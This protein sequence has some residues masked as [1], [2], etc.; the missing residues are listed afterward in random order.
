[1]QGYDALRQSAAWLD[2][3]GRGVIT[4]TG[5][6]RV[7]LL[8]AITTNHIEQLKAGE[9]C[10]A[11]FLNAQGRIQADLNAFSL[12]DR[13]VIDTEPETAQR[14][15]E[16][17]EHYIIADDVTLEDQTAETSVLAVEGPHAAKALAGA[18]IPFPEAPFA[19]VEWEHGR[20]VVR[21]SLTGVPGFRLFVPG[22]VKAGAIARLESAGIPAADSAAARVVRLEHFKPRYGED[23]FDTTLPQETRQLHAVHFNKGCYLGQEIVERVR[24]RG[25]VHRLLAG[26]LIAA[27]EPPE[28]G[29]PVMAGDIEAGKITSAALSP[30]LGKVAALAYLRREHTEPG[31]TL[32]C[33]GN[34][35]EVCLPYSP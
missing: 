33:A 4:A 11:F 30:A 29:T 14:V 7:R 20:I 23:I 25:L 31:N 26:L 34:R 18:G 24:S 9:G 15:L 22:G 35:A 10:Y 21:L 12:S 19:H 28:A 13:L 16:H 2:L 3:T 17:I 27:A 6:D 5:E 32:T 8:H 1:M